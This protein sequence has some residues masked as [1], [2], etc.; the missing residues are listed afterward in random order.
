[1]PILL[2]FLAITFSV[3]P[4]HV[5]YGIE[6]VTLPWLIFEVLPLGI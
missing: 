1:M 2:E 3:Y 4:L 5:V 6:Q